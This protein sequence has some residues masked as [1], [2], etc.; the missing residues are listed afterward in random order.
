MLNVSE[1][2]LTWG[3]GLRKGKFGIGYRYV[4]ETIN[5][6]E[7]YCVY[8]IPREGDMNKSFLE[9]LKASIVEAIALTDC[10][11]FASAC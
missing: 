10:L 9:A 7:T 5:A 3:R 8:T 1:A 4:L 6:S 11:V 2:I